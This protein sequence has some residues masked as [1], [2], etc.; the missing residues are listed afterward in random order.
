M[1]THLLPVHLPL[2]PGVGR[3]ASWM[4][5]AQGRFWRSEHLPP[6]S[7]RGQGRGGRLMQEAGP[8]LGSWKSPGFHAPHPGP[9]SPPEGVVLQWAPP[10]R[11]QGRWRW[12][13]PGV[14]LLL[15]AS[16]RPGHFSE[17]GCV[18]WAELC[19]EGLTSRC[20]QVPSLQ[21]LSPTQLL[22]PPRWA[23]RWCLLLPLVP[24]ALRGR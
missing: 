24:G 4:S 7:P 20:F 22:V 19:L 8:P 9:P 3:A 5:K 6:S 23:V 15:V 11:V 1:G 2:S 13:H 14:L 17:S 18:W 16:C 21:D 10:W 12:S